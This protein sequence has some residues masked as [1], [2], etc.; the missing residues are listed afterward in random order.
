ME[1]KNWT[2]VRQFVGYLRFDSSDELRVLNE[3]W[4]LDGLFTNYLLAQ[5]KLTSKQ[6]YG[7]KVTKRYDRAQSPHERARVHRDVTEIARAA[8][9]ATFATIHLAALCDQIQTLTA[10]LEHLSLT[11]SLAP[12]RRVD[13]SFNRPLQP[14]VLDE[15]TNQAPR[16]I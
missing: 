15:A 2:H 10:Q 8:M 7:A 6:R 5:H 9:D 11:K 14:E 1:Q 16:R 3:I 4:A 12:V 13:K